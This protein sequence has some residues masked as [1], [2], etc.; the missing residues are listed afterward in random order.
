MVIIIRRTAPSDG[1][2]NLRDALR[3]LNLRCLLSDDGRVRR[4]GFLVNWGSTR[5]IAQGALNPVHAVGVARDKLAT[6]TALANAGVSVPQFWTDRTQAEAERGKSILLERHTLTGESGAG[7]VVKRQGEGLAAAPLYVRYVR[8]QREFRVHTF[9][10]RAIA[11]QE[12]KRESDNEQTSDQKLIRNRA[13]GWVFCVNDI[14][15]PQGLRDVAV[16]ATDAVQLDFGAVDMIQGLDGK[17]YVLE[18][19]TKP[20]LESPTILSAY[21]NA[22]KEKVNGS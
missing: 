11:V 10:G 8:K 5:P 7:I 22:I 19:N 13:N 15:E 17:L 18:I 16:A 14:V 3:A 1:A 4:R 12:K 9:A 20:G 2:R 21:A 6:L